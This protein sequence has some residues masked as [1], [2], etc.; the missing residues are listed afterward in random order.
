MNIPKNNRAHSEYTK[1]IQKRI[2]ESIRLHQRFS[3]RLIRNIALAAEKVIECHRKGNKLILFGNGGSAADAQHIACELVGRFLVERRPLDAIALSTNSS[4]IT[5][6]GN[7]YG[8]DR[9]FERQIEASAKAGDVIMGIST[10]GDSSNVI[11]AMEA[12]KKMGCVTIGMTGQGGGKMKA[13]ADILLD[14]PSNGP[15]PR[16]QEAHILIGHIMCELVER[17]VQGGTK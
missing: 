16:I 11:R 1:L 2:D 13:V 8:Y 5:C 17:A 10:S 15:S 7:D 4:V 3:Q 9:I 14:V 6:L 12:A